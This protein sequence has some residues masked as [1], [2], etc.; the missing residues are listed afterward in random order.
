MLQIIL[1]QTKLTQLHSA[2]TAGKRIDDLEDQ[3][4]NIVGSLNA[5][6]SFTSIAITSAR[7]C[8]AMDAGSSP[9][10]S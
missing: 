6:S 7:C 9:S 4:A 10:D 5:L 2:Y 8:A 1:T 3:I